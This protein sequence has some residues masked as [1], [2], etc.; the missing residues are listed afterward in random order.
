MEREVGE[1]VLAHAGKLVE[2]VQDRREEEPRQEQRRKEVLDVAVERVQRGDREREPGDD[3]REERSEREREP[4][5]RAR[6]G[7][8]PRLRDDTTPSMTAK[9][10]RFVPTID[11]GTSCR[12]KRTL[13]MRFA[14]SSRLRDD[15]CDGGREEHPRGEAA[16]QEEPVVAASDL[17]DLPEERRRRA[18]R[19]A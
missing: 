14:F 2:A 13:R 5:R 16:E 10:T 4:D 7:Q 11:S 18:G 19:R 9:L 1:R 15:A 8:L 3:A 12:G 6:L 17:G